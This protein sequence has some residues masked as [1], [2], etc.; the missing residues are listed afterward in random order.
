MATREALRMQFKSTGA[1]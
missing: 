1:L